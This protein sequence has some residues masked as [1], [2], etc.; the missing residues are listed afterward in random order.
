MQNIQWLTTTCGLNTY[1]CKYVGKIDE[2]NHVIIRAHA[3]DPGVMVSQATFLHNTKIT[4]SAIN[5]IKR[6][7]KSR[8]KNHPKGRAIS[9]MEMLQVMIGYP[10]IHTDMVFENVSTLPLEQRTGVLFKINPTNNAGCHNDGDEIMSISY[11]VRQEKK[12]LYGD[13]LEM[14]NY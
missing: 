5:E 9:L 3:H 8:S 13:N 7:E 12:F 11:Q 1:I 14:K 10:Q 2:N 6:F 4:S